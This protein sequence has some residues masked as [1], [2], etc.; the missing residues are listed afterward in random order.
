MQEDPLLIEAQT[1]IE[2]H[3]KKK[4]REILRRLIKA[5]PKNIN[6]WLWLSVSVDTIAYPC[7]RIRSTRRGY[8]YPHTHTS[9]LFSKKR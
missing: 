3:D 2:L 1:A 6:Y 5:D 7:T 9:H 8:F 4:A